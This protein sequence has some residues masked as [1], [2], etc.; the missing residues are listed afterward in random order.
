[1]SNR[2]LRVVL[3]GGWLSILVGVSILG[4]SAYWTDR[5][6]DPP[7]QGTPDIVLSAVSRELRASQGQRLVEPGCGEGKVSLYLASTSGASVD[8]V[9]FNAGLVGVAMDQ[10]ERAGLGDSVY[11]H[12]GDAMSVDYSPYDGVYLFMSALFNERIL[13]RLL[14]QMRPGSRIVSLSHSSKAYPPTYTRVIKGQGRDWLLH[15]WVVP[16]RVLLHAAV[17][18]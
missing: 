9:E 2:S 8:C 14:H 7:F 18:S 4:L 6:T 13:P 5:L 10:V 3:F 17:G 1:M 15:V 16:E 12:H 11:V